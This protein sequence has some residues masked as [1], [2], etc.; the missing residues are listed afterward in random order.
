VVTRASYTKGNGN[1][2]KIKHDKTYETQYLHMQ[3]FAKGISVGTHVKQGQVIGYV[4]SSG[5]ST[6]PH[7]HFEVRRAGRPTNP[8]G[9]RSVKQDGLSGEELTEFTLIAGRLR[10][11]L[12]YVAAMAEPGVV[13]RLA[14]LEPPSYSEEL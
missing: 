8:L 12:D 14:S 10:A 4:G 3:K 13:M 1:F 5:L 2:V 9:I 7:L 11:D 6:G